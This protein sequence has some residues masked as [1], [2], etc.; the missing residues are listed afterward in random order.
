MHFKKFCRDIPSFQT[1]HYYI[2]NNAMGLTPCH[3]ESVSIL[4]FCWQCLNFCVNWG[5][6]VSHIS[7][8]NKKK[9]FTFSASS[10]VG[11]ISM[12]TIK[13]DIWSRS[14]G[15]WQCP[16]MVDWLWVGFYKKHVIIC[17]AM[18]VGRFGRLLIPLTRFLVF[19]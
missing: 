17:H 12:L 10:K 9:R 8:W 2:K 13:V 5:T 11:H 6:D 4:S 1:L 19:W 15:Q 16:S 14:N 3:S 18:K 7:F